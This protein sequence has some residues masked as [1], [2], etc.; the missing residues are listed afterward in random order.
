MLMGKKQYLS[1]TPEEVSA[2]TPEE[3][4]AS[5]NAAGGTA[6]PIPDEGLM[7]DLLGAIRGALAPAAQWD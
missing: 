5:I 3:V 2:S 1:S 4:S 6:L 7:G